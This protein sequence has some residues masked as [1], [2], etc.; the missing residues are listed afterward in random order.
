MA[1]RANGDRRPWCDMIPVVPFEMMKPDGGPWGYVVQGDR[2]RVRPSVKMSFQRCRDAE[3]NLLP[4]DQWTWVEFFHNDGD[5]TVRFER[6][7]G[8]ANDDGAIHDRLFGL[9]PSLLS[10]EPINAGDERTPAP[11]PDVT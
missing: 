10:R 7:D 5:W 9:N 4:E 11:N 6:W 1:V 8:D 2:L 3:G